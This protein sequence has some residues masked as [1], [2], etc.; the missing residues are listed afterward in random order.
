MWNLHQTLSKLL[1]VGV[2]YDLAR[3]QAMTVYQ[4]KHIK[5][6]F[7]LH[8][9]KILD[10]WEAKHVSWLKI[11]TSTDEKQIQQEMQK[12]GIRYES[13]WPLRPWDTVW[14][15]VQHVHVPRVATG[16]CNPAWTLLLW[17]VPFLPEIELQNCKKIVYKSF[18][19]SHRN[20]RISGDNPF[21]LLTLLMHNV[22]DF[23]VVTQI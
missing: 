8:N 4:K 5:C 19:F 9:F 22:M 15:H 3:H 7:M 6:T 2:K 17:Q 1:W 16:S 18:S 13:N 12:S 10:V 20:G 14:L 21:T 11:W 23:G